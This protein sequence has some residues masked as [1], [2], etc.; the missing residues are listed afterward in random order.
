MI[1]G[2]YRATAI[3]GEPLIRGFLA[4]RRIRGKEDPIRFTERRG[5]ASIARPAGPLTWLHAASVGEAISVLSLVER[6]R[7][8]RPGLT[9]LV[10]TGTVTSAE[11]MAE[12]LPPGVLHQYAPVDL[13]GW[14]RRFLDHWQPDLVLWVESEFWP[15]LLCA[16]ASRNIPL[17]LINARISQRS[18]RG[19]QRI[20][21]TIATL[22]KCFSLCLAQSEDDGDKLKA[23]GATDVRVPGNLKFTAAPLPVNGDQ[24]TELSR[25]IGDRPVWAA[26]STHEGEEIVI[27]QAHRNISENTPEVL[28]LIAPRH[29]IGRAHV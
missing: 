7:A 26:V 23:L 28:T 3:I 8:E 12:R 29:Q 20:K 9:L 1:L 14:V 17:I 15:T 18:F 11:I 19:W 13:P 25:Q 10:T 4:R 24:L 22:L 27:A 16:I 2:L 6:L 21:G 5:I